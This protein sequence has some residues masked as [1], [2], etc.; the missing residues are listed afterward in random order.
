M[1]IKHPVLK[2]YGSKFRISKW[3]LQHFPK[4]RHYVE[5]F[6]GAANILLLKEPSKLETYNDLNDL[7]VNFFQT[8]RTKP[9]ELIHQ[10]NLT[11]Y[12]R[13][14]FEF[15]LQTDEV[16]D[17]EKSRRLYFRLWLSYQ[18]SMQTC[19]GNFRRHKAG[20]RPVTKDI[21]PENLMVAAK[22]LKQ[23]VIEHR[24]AL[25]LIQ[26]LDSPDTL[27]YLD[28]PYVASTRVVKQAYSHEMANEKHR[29]FAEILFNLQG[30]AIVSGY[31]S[32][33]YRELFEERKWQRVDKEALI[34]SGGKRIESLWLSPNTVM[35]L[36]KNG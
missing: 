20:R 1:Q 10:I 25:K 36:S 24:D 19:K 5:P 23:V 30:M 9:T 34:M 3:I 11:P 27:F 6:G 2:Y 4:H 22:R 8:L 31:P 21:N 18:S 13:K 33:L 15:C 26:E 29:E 12:S 16:S 7:I 14:E 35:Q 32:P 28:P 17:L